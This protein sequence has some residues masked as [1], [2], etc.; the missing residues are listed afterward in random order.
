MSSQ[1]ETYLEKAVNVVT[2]DGN[3]YTGILK[4]FDQA[5]NLVLSE[6]FLTTW[7]PLREDIQTDDIVIRGDTVVLVA[8][9]SSEELP[10]EAQKLQSI[11]Y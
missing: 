9:R 11:L 8:I 10:A 4:G 2:T 7:S 6:S 3:F 1:L 5:T